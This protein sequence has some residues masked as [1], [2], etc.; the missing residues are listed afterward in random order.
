MFQYVFLD[1]QNKIKI[2]DARR[3]LLLLRHF[4]VC[5]NMIV[6]SQCRMIK[7]ACCYPNKMNEECLALE[8]IVVVDTVVYIALFFCF[9]AR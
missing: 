9:L 3:V 6:V 1:S 4:M 8:K 5:R 7:A 2:D